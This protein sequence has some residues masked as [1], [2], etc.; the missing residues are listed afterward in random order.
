MPCI[1]LCY[2]IASSADAA[3]KEGN[4]MSCLETEQ[5]SK[6][7]VN[8]LKF[9]EGYRSTPYIGTEGYLHIGY[10]QKLSNEKGLN[11]DEWNVTT[12]PAHAEY[13]LVNK[14]DAILYV[15]KTGVHKSAFNK[16][17]EEGQAVLVSMAYQM[18]I[19]GLYKFYDM[20]TAIYLGDDE[21]AAYEMLSSKWA[22]QTPAR[23]R[24]HAETMRT[25]IIP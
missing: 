2:V 14:V 18:G 12:T 1:L 4:R 11:P 17:D 6:L 7:A 23:A 16:L 25:G 20:W 19:Q 5:T 24:R 21:G 9:E 13:I 10:G 15:L 3:Y 8:L 22:T